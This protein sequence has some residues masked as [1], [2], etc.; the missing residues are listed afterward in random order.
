M[1]TLNALTAYHAKRGVTPALVEAVRTFV[2][3]LAPFAPFIA[4]ELWERLGGP[5]S[6]MQQPWPAWDEALAAA[7]TVTLVVQ[8]DGRVRERLSAAAD[9]TEAAARDLALNAPA[10]QR[11]LGGRPIA[12]T[13]YVPGKL[14]NLVRGDGPLNEFSV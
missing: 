14:I 3:L 5:Y 2:R 13:V 8:V 1:E 12:R 4:E 10:V 9:I 11:A 7:E 6:V